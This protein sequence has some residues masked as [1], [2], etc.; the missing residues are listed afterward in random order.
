MQ[1]S[2]DDVIQQISEALAQADIDFIEEIANKILTKKVTAINNDAN[3][4][5]FEQEE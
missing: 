4:D 3:E 2:I 1:V 5:V